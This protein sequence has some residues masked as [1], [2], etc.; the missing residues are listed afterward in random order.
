MIGALVS[1]NPL[2]SSPQAP[3]PFSLFPFLYPLLASS[4][5]FFFLSGCL[6][7]VAWRAVESHSLGAGRA[8]RLGACQALSGDANL[9]YFVDSL[10]ETVEVV[11]Y[12]S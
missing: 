11:V 5:S 7:R 8:H 1:P 4:S 3:W 2:V 6:D 10:P 9:E 12:Q